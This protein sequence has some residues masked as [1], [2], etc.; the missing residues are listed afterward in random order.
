MHPVIPVVE[1][2]PAVKKGLWFFGGVTPCHVHIVQHHMLVGS[3]DQDDPPAFA[4]DRSVECFYIR[5]DCPPEAGAAW[6]DGG[7]AL[8]LRE[9]VFMAER[10]LGWPVHWAD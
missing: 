1:R 4:E 2:L 10:R 3:H 7:A 8:S 9:A 6:L 5:F